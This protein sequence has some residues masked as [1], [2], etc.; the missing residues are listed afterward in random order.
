M[1]S[2]TLILKVTN[3]C[4]LRCKYCYNA[5]T[6]FNRPVIDPAKVDKMIGILAPFDTLHIIFHGGEP[7]M[8]G[9]DFFEKVMRIEEKYYAIRGTKFTN[10]VQTNGTLI[11]GKWISFFKK[12]DFHVGVSF[13]GIYNDKYRGSTEKV[14]E[15]IKRLKKE[16][17]LGGVIAVASDP[18]YDVDANYE[19]L[20]KL[21]APLDFNF[22]FPEGNARSIDLLT[23]ESYTEQILKLF[24]KWVHDKD[25][26][27]VRSL[28][29]LCHQ[30]LDRNVN[31]CSNGSCIGNFFCIDAEGTIYGCGREEMK[32]YAYGNIDSISSIEDIHKSEGFRKIL[33]GSI[34]RRDNCSK[35]CAYYSECRG[36]CTDDAILNGDIE[37]PNEEWCKQYRTLYSHVKETLEQIKSENVD[38]STLNPCFTRILIKATGLPEE[39]ADE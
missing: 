25:G 30:A 38:L 8:G 35:T 19:Y 7:L 31:L 39:N 5:A 37:H 21:G 32:N 15:A 17:L 33:V 23:N 14:V 3:A 28:G 4:N 12:H 36:G 24:D 22:V 11:D 1:K 10:S 34:R 27:P 9:I 26:V 16:K 20:K 18:E 13:D 2:A 29:I 6:M